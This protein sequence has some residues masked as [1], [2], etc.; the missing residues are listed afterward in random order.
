MSLSL[1]RPSCW[2]SDAD[3]A[4]LASQ[5]S[6]PPIYPVPP[7]SACYPVSDPSGNCAE[8]I[9]RAFDPNWRPV[10]CSLPISKRS[11]FRTGRLGSVS[12]DA[13]TAEDVQAAV[14]LAEK[15]NLRVVVKSTGRGNSPAGSAGAAGCWVQGGGH[16]ILSPQFGIGVDNAIQFTVVTSSG[17]HLTANVYSHPDLFWANLRGGGGGTYGVLTSVAYDTHPE[18]YVVFVATEAAATPAIAQSIGGYAYKATSGTVIEATQLFPSFYSVYTGIFAGNP[19]KTDG[20]GSNAELVSRLL[21]RGLIENDPE[22]VAETLL[23]MNNTVIYHLVAGG[24]ASKVDPDSTGLNPA[25]RTAAA[26]VVLSEGW[27]EGTRVS[28]VRLIHGTLKGY[29][30]V[31][32]ELLGLGGGAYFNEAS[33]YESNFQETFFGD[34]HSKLEA[35]KDQYD[36][37]GLFVVVEGVGFERFDDTLDCLKA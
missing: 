18:E 25:W 31:L 30:G 29:L 32:E 2:P 20:E 19:S 22:T 26:H 5:L 4:L 34:H 35:I 12:V 11:S 23:S 33:L 36:P 15:W 9:A 1:S 17:S 27:P 24:A 16:E 37:A 13:Q 6:Q 14:V 28:D 10:Q 7:E 21:P 3:F 8:V